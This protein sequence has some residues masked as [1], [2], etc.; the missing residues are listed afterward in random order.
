[1]KSSRLNSFG[2]VKFVLAILLAFAISFVILL[3]TTKEPVAAIV[4]LLIGPLTSVRRFSTVIETMIPI[5]FAGV[6][7]AIMFRANQFNLAA[8]GSIF[9]GALFGA[10]VAINMPGNTFIVKAIAILVGGLIGSVVCFIPGL[11]KVKYKASEL[12][13]SIMLNSIA[14]YLGL[15]IFSMVAKDPNSAFAASY[16]IAKG[17]SLLKVLPGT[18]LHSG[19][20]IVF[21]VVILAYIYMYK[22]KWGYKLRAVGSNS[23]FAKTIGVNTGSVILSAQLI[24]GFIAGMGGAVE[25]LGIYTRFQWVALPGYGFDGV[26]VATIARNNPLFVP[27]AAFL[28]SYLRIGADYMY[29]QGDVASEIVAIIQGLVIILVSAEAFLATYKHKLVTMDSK[30]QIKKKEAE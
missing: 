6:A 30:I 28:L 7:V 12:V 27:I 1:M 25:M 13:S 9:L 15:Y 16:Q 20:I 8:E 19:I 22:T 29:R 10:I 26:I 14:L 5:T 3:F 17:T 23:S 4:N 24:G 11:L 21:V 18:R 2:L